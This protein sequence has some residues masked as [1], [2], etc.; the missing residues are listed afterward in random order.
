MCLAM[1]GLIGLAQTAVQYAAES[2]VA[3]AQNAYAAVNAQSANDAAILKYSQELSRQREEAANAAR[4]RQSAY[5][6]SLN[7]QGTALASSQNEGGS[8]NLTLMDLARQ[9]A[10]EISLIDEN[11]KIQ[12]Q[13][14]KEN[15]YAMHKEAQS[16]INGVQTT[17]GP[18]LLSAAVSGLGIILSTRAAENSNQNSTPMG[19]K[20][21]GRY[22]LSVTG[23]KYVKP[24]PKLNAFSSWTEAYR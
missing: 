9:G 18:S 6:T 8:T 15:L 7:H 10:N 23:S 24:K 16:R 21:N 12:Q 11:Q 19:N 22:A 13:T 1:S 4:Q 2:Q 14:G 5:L 3:E 17:S 20:D